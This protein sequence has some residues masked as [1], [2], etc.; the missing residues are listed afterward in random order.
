MLHMKLLTAKQVAV[1][2]Q[3]SPARVYEMTR[4]HLIPSVRMGRQIR[5]N[6]EA[7]KNWITVGGQQDGTIAIE[8]N[9]LPQYNLQENQ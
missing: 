1:I 9:S 6:E 8:E 5:F 4:L 3:V 7:L 2:L